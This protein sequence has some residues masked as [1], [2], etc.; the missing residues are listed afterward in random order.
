MEI[1]ELTEY[2]SR[3]DAVLAQEVVTH[4]II[5][6]VSVSLKT[7]DEEY[8]SKIL[9]AKLD[10][11]T[12]FLVLDSLIPTEGNALAE[13]KTEFAAT[14]DYISK[15]T[16]Y[17]ARFHLIIW[18]V[19]EHKGTTVVYA[20]PPLDTKIATEE[21]NSRPGEYDPLWVKIPLFK[22][23]LRLPVTQI[24]YR[25]LVFED[26]LVSDSMP[27]VEKLGRITLEFDDGEEIIIH[28][29]YHSKGGHAIEFK[30]EDNREEDLARIDQHLVSVYTTRSLTKS[31]KE[32][33]KRR[34]AVKKNNE[35]QIKLLMYVKDT[36][37]ATSLQQMFETH[38]AQM[39]FI[40]DLEKFL[41]TLEK[42][43]INI[44][45]IDNRFPDMD[46][47]EVARSIHAIVQGKPKQPPVILL[48]DDLS[49]D[50]VVYAQ[51]CNINHL[52]S[53]SDFMESACNILAPLVNIQSWHCKE[54]ANAHKK[55]LIIDDD[56]NL[57]FPVSHGLSQ[58]GFDV[59]VAKTGGEGLRL[60]KEN[61]PDCILLEIALR[62]G[63][64]VTVCR[65]LRKVPFTSKIPIIVL[66]VSKDKADYEA[67]KPFNVQKYLSKPMA[68]HDIINLIKEMIENE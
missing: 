19:G 38:D 66:T 56:Q 68:N 15:G 40:D 61:R 65:M 25:A 10:G 63:D 20:T 45:L 14:C 23:E 27:A 16:V 42:Y 60:A 35:N 32:D 6:E 37:Y 57:I 59:L 49:E 11:D 64:G 4:A 55:V 3:Y 13:K 18:G 43:S 50:A 12:P 41:S 1:M 22:T 39:V 21:F 31:S 52:Y 34:G 53:R 36:E 9:H 28:G 33:T 47:W 8:F 62:S 44:V 67:V 30:Y 5:K 54:D 46:L 7:Q 29:Q 48:S 24:S 51:Y 17:H 58:L 26:R 2:R